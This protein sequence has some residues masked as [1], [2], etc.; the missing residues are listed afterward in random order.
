MGC[1][2]RLMADKSN[3]KEIVHY[4]GKYIY[5]ISYQDLD[6]KHETGKNI[7][8][9]VPLKLNDYHSD[10]IFYNH[11]SCAFVVGYVLFLA[12]DFLESLQFACQLVTAQQ[13]VI[14]YTFVFC[15]D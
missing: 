7:G 1:H 15:T 11:T 2:Y 4:F 12:S 9:P 6:V 14:L 13:H 3:I 5:S 10:L 8:P